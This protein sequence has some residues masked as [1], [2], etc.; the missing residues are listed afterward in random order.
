MDDVE[1]RFERACEHRRAAGRLPFELGGARQSVVPR[2]S[3]PLG[4]EALSQVLDRLAVLRVDEH[5]TSEACTGGQGAHHVAV[6]EAYRR[7]VR[8][9]DLEGRHAALD[10]VPHLLLGVV[11]PPGDGHVQAVVAHCAGRF[12][13]PGDEGL[14]EA[15]AALRMHEIDDGRRAA[16]EP[17]RRPALEVVGRDGPGHR[18]RQV[19]VRVDAAGENILPRSVQH[20]LV[21]GS[22]QSGPDLDD[23][24]LAAPDVARPTVVGGDHRA[25]LDQ[26]AHRL[27]PSL[28]ADPAG[29]DVW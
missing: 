4:G 25:V 11:P 2:P 18:Q 13:P 15:L 27:F 26:D 17:G 9:V 12:P 23:A 16:R 29:V 19:D 5:E 21:G 28:T 3:V 14:R 24:A 1:R 22:L 20:P 10:A 8:E 7:L 6:V